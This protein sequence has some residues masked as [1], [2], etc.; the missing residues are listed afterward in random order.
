MKKAKRIIPTLFLCSLLLSPAA[1]ANSGEMSWSGVSS[2]GA[3]VT[4]KNC[5][6][7]VEKE[8]LTFDISQFPDRSYNSEYKFL[9]YT[10]SV[11]A[12]YTFYN[13][14]DYTVTATLAF[15]FGT[16]PDYI[17][18]TSSDYEDRYGVSVNGSEIQAQVRHTLSSMNGFD[19][20]KEL[21][22]LTE[23]Y[24]YDD[25]YSPDTP[26]YRQ[27]YT[28]SWTD[29]SQSSAIFAFIRSDGGRKTKL[30]LYGGDTALSR[31]ESLAWVK[32]G[33]TVTLWCIGEYIEQPNWTIYT[34]PSHRETLSGTVT[35]EETKETTF[36]QF[37]MQSYDPET[38]ISETDWY[39]A[40]V[41]DLKRNGDSDNACFTECTDKDFDITRSLL[42][43]YQYEL[44]LQPGERITNTVTAP[45]YP[46]I[47]ANYSPNIYKYTYLLSP[48]KTWSDF[49]ALRITVNT[50]FYITKSNTE[51]FEKTDNGYILSLDGLPDGELNFTMCKSKNPSPAIHPLVFIAYGA[52][53]LPVLTALTALA[54]GIAALVRHKRRQKGNSESR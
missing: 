22:K 33:G 38:G 31:D 19:F 39:N 32:N 50:P 34:D 37:A 13:P 52:V 44:T 2:T 47:D 16:L 17:Y 14:A 15:P 3:I 26:V 41:G 42:R 51:S 18:F 25:F 9:S 53:L 12:E 24:V 8:L 35:L 45:I 49:G 6:I 43:W 21:P 5:P 40:I 36:L 28:V 48:A 10:D 20:E 7:V 27:T 54:I 11:T 29:P 23:E 1:S 4:D 30:I 46:T